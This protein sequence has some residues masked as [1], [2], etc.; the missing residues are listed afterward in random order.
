MKSRNLR[1]IMS[2]VFRWAGMI[3]GAT[4]VA[5]LS[6]DLRAVEL[7][8]RKHLIVQGGHCNTA[9]PLDV[10]GDGR[11]DVVAS[12]SSSVTARLAPDWRESRLLHQLDGEVCIHSAVLDV[13]QDGDLDWAG[14]VA[15]RHPFWLENPGSSGNPA[16]VWVARRIDS[17][18]TGIHCFTSADVDRDGRQDLVVNNFEPQQG[19]RDS[20]VW[21]R[22][23]VDARTTKK[24]WPRFTF[25]R[26]DA[27]GGSHYMGVGDVTGDGLPE[28]GV[29]AK[30]S[31]F[32]DGNWFA[33]WV[34]PG[35]DAAT[36][37]QP[38]KKIVLAEN[39]IGATNLLPA[40]VNADGRVDWIGS[41]GHGRG[42][43]WFE[44]PSWRQ[45][46]IDDAIENPHSLARG[47]FDHDG[48]VDVATCG[49]G[50]RRVMWY[51]NNGQG[52]FVLHTVDDAQESYDLRA[53]D[54]DGDGDLDL[55]NAGR[56]SGNVVWYEN[57]LQTA[58]P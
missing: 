30:G 29:G 47:D 14:A 4:V 44:N 21:Y 38:W 58:T 54:M 35:V 2:R 40:D 3:A 45:H 46:T 24:D 25:A 57:R 48:D 16:N 9:V 34:H 51:E 22:A 15:H 55:L 49:F 41:R 50:S 36:R 28:I 31:P 23:P 10:N 8:W 33:F 19:V 7:E 56:A 11:L 39:E 52:T 27:R 37:D 1:Q 53:V 5:T 32:A 17:E 43:V 20:I 18:L 6:S 26:G 12:Y 13:D 42:V